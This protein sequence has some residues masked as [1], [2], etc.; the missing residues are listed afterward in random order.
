MTDEITLREPVAEDGMHLHR[1]VAECPPLDPNSSYCNLLH[2]SHFA[3]T[4]AAAEMNGE[5]V[6]FVSG[7]CLPDRDDTYFLW[8]VAVGEAARGR[9][10][11][12]KMIMH[13][14][15]R[16]RC[17]EVK[18]LETTITEDNRASW[19]LFESA[20]NHL[21]A[22]L[23]HSVMFDKERHFLG[24]HDTEMLVRIGPFSQV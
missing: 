16:Q 7:Y 11:A 12:R 5:L 6:G 24:Q 2:C 9:G 20:A 18:Y 22:P 19:A 15:Q 10:L 13:I 21:Q 3:A 4:S 1:L 8:Q 14:L 23:K 17:A